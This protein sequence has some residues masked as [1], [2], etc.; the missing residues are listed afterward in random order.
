MV[1]YMSGG[2]LGGG[3][4]GSKRFFGWSSANKGSCM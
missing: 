3:Y 1:D 2:G 4:G